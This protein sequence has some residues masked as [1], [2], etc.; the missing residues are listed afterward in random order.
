MADRLK[1]EIEGYIMLILFFG[2]VVPCFLVSLLFLERTQTNVAIG[3]GISFLSS[4]MIGVLVNRFLQRRS[5]RRFY[6]EVI[7]PE[8]ARRKVDMG[9]VIA[10]LS[11][12]DVND[13][14]VNE[15]MRDLVKSLPLLTEVLAEN[16]QYY[17][18]TP[19]IQNQ[20]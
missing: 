15:R 12:I 7:L 14:R 1:P 19:A 6:R 5:H 9:A 2:P 10:M 16:D 8:A 3:L 4:I 20:S 17:F 11:Q 18:D 13:Q